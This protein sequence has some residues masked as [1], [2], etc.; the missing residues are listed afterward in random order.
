LFGNAQTVRLETNV[1]VS[2]SPFEIE[3]CE[4]TSLKGRAW[5]RSIV[6]IC[7]ETYSMKSI[8][9]LFNVILTVAV[10]VLFA[11]HFS[12]KKQGGI[13]AVAGAAGTSGEL[14]VV[15]FNSDSLMDQYQ[16]FKDERAIMEQKTKDAE[17]RLIGEQKKF[18]KEANEFQ[19]RA[20]FLTIT[21]KEAKQEKLYR[22]QQRLMQ[23]EQTLSSD[24]QK[25][26]A[27]VSKRIF[28][29][30]EVFLKDYAK[31]NNYTYVLSYTRGGGIWYADQSLDVTPAILKELNDRYKNRKA[32]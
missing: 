14:N 5:I 1:K 28:D 20:Q 11:L 19:Q 13:T 27:E 17:S 25:E 18:E 12:S 22:E 8:N 9:L 16:M 4:L 7:R 32:E 24:L 10:V 29:T 21:D 2:Q 23:M 30:I 15:F 31:E 26:E 3:F 6:Y